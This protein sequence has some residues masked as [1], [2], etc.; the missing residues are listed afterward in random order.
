M[1]RNLTSG[2]VAEVTAQ[3]LRPILLAEFLFDSSSL[4]LWTG[5]GN[6]S[7]SG[8]TWTGAGDLGAVSPIGETSDMKAVGATF[9]LSGVPASMISI[10]LSEPYQ[11]RIARLYFGALDANGAVVV[12]P[13]IVF[14]GFLDVMEIEESGETATISVTSENALV[15][16]ERPRERRYTAEDQKIDYP[17]DKGFE[18]VPALQDFN[19]IWGKTG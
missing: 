16:L 15:A 10:A 4:R 8:E 12:D 7:W 11:G 5:V 13:Y 19:F 14:E 17:D 6:L 9:T 1:A 3:S 18:Q 2:L